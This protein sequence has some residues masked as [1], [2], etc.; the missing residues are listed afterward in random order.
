MT[1]KEAITKC[2]TTIGRNHNAVF[3][4]YNTAYGSRMYGTLNGVPKNKCVE[5]PVDENLMCGIAMGMSLQGFLPIVCFERHDFILVALD[6]I[7]NHI[8]KMPRLSGDQ[9]NFPVVLR[10][11]VGSNKPLDPGIQHTDN[12]T[13]I[14]KNHTDITIHDMNSVDKIKDVTTMT[15]TIKKPLFLV[16]HKSLY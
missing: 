16:E 10:A 11:I 6:A 2:M 13:G 1:Y 3:I 14:I 12:Y 4:G 9:F 5:T 15:N 7:V 8:N